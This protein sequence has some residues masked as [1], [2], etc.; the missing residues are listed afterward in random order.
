M[1]MSVVVVVAVAVLAVALLT[2]LLLSVRTTAS[3]C[4]PLWLPHHVPVGHYEAQT[5]K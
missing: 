1:M 2:L 5:L 3:P 4:V